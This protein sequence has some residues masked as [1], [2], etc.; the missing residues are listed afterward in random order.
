MFPETTYGRSSITYEDQVQ[1]VKILNTLSFNKDKVRLIVNILV[2]EFGE[3]MYL[4]MFR[5]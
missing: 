2:N 4:R 5:Q 3:L 1:T